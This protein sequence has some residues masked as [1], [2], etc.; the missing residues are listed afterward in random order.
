MGFYTT[1]SFWHLIINHLLIK[2]PLTV[3]PLYVP[4][5]VKKS[6]DVNFKDQIEAFYFNKGSIY[7]MEKERWLF[8]F[9]IQGILNR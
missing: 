4:V 2:F 7:Y 3:H 9:N 5:A 1:V 6:A 8:L